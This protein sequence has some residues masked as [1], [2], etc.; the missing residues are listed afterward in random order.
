MNI[1]SLPILAGALGV[2]LAFTALTLADEPE[3][4][5]RPQVEKARREA[6]A[7]RDRAEADRRDA[8]PRRPEARREGRE[9]EAN[10]PR[11]NEA[12]QL[13]AQL[14]ELI[15]AGRTEEAERLKRRL[16]EM[17]ARAG[18]PQNRPFSSGGEPEDIERRIKHLTAAAENLHAAGN[19]ELA[20]NLQRQV[21]QMRRHAQEPRGPGLPSP[22]QP[23]F[24]QPGQPE[25]NQ[26]RPGQ[27]GLRQPEPDQLRPGQPGR[28]QPGVD[29][30]TEELHA[31]VRRLNSELQEL[32][33]QV[34]ELRKHAEPRKK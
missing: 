21:E 17:E 27:P 30:R 4:K 5:E 11:A 20:E 9:G 13:R 2:T 25:P 14:R 32:R 8:E 18:E 12:E 28:G 29:P 19:H 10:R 23:G 26:I 6:E 34:Q 31:T 1:R 33:E 22:H 24:N 15:S 7:Q 3:R 16:G